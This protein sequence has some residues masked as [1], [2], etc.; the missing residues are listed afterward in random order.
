MPHNGSPFSNARSIFVASHVGFIY[1]RCRNTVHGMWIARSG[2]WWLNC[3]TCIQ[4]VPCNMHKVNVCYCLSIYLY[5]SGLLHWYLGQSKR[6]SG[7]FWKMC[8]MDHITSPRTALRTKTNH[9]RKHQ[10]YFY[11]KEEY[12]ST[13]R[14]TSS[15]SRTK[16]Q[17]LNVSCI[18]LQ[19]SLLNP[20]KPGV[21]LR[22]KM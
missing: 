17:S 8:K 9:N 2:L 18:L 3:S 10:V 19:L 14:K 11:D 21:N 6:L 7:R 1:P 20:L 12:S 22:M 13:Y 5:R 15:I 16:S 4:Y